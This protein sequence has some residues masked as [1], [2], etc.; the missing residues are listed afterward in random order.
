[1]TNNLVKLAKNCTT[2]AGMTTKNTP[3]AI[4]FDK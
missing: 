4:Q 3:D 2:V 1:M